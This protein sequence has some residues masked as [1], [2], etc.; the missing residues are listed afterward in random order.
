MSGRRSSRGSQKRLGF[1]SR[2]DGLAAVSGMIADCEVEFE[3][4]KSRLRGLST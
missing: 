4:V 3:K 2:K 1:I